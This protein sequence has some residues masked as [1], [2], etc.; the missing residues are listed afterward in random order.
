MRHFA[1]LSLLLLLASIIGLST[2]TPVFAQSAFCGDGKINTALGCI[3]VGGIEA[4]E[5]II[6]WAV[7]I[8]GG[9]TF[10]II[11]LAAL[12]ITTAA[13]DPKRVKAGQE[14]LT[15]ALS[16]LLLIVFAVVLLNLLGVK[17]LNLGSIGFDVPKLPPP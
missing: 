5:A 17:I 13:G 7:G 4:F 8:G 12:Q 16:G 2:V 9:I 14:L 1:H 15:A 6:N 11:I 10:I 3:N